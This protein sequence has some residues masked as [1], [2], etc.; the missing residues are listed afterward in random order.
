MTQLGKKHRKTGVWRTV[1]FIILKRCF[2]HRE[3]SVKR[4][5]TVLKYVIRMERLGSNNLHIL[6]AKIFQKGT[7]L[8]RL[9]AVCK[10]RC[11]GVKKR[12][13]SFD[14]SK[15]SIQTVWKTR[16]YN[17]WTLWHLLELNMHKSEQLYLQSLTHLCHISETF[18]SACDASCDPT[19]A[20]C[21]LA[22]L[23]PSYVP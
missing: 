6:G 16:L 14:E 8:S 17:F 12:P 3:S 5:P 15:I 7:P 19:A 22:T 9:A 10:L 18:D 4:K 11:C 20:L 23:P 1:S 21:D 13:L 2:F